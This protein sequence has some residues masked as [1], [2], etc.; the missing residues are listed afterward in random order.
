MKTTNTRRVCPLTAAARCAA[1]AG[2]LLLPASPLLAQTA[3][4]PSL[5]EFLPVSAQYQTLSTGL[6]ALLR[7]EVQF[8]TSGAASAFKVIDIGIPAPQ[9]DGMIRYDF[10]T[11]LGAW[12]YPG[13]DGQLRVAAVGS[14]GSGVSALSNAFSYTSSSTTTT[15]GDIA[16]SVKITSP[17]NGAV[18]RAGAPI[19]LAASASDPDG[20]VGYVEIYVGS[21]RVLQDSSSP[22][23]KTW[24]TSV[25]GTYTV[26]A[27]AYDNKGVHTTSAPITIKVQ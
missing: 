21:T 15:G 4:N 22:Y 17:A 16:P 2:L 14:G 1:V 26:T 19:S 8:Y 10:S 20:K 7:Y 27:I 24:K 12:A 3:T 11:Q 13:V 25:P 9:A 23:Q 5:V 6:P 18:F